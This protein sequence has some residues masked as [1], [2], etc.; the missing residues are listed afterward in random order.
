M[1]QQG[2]FPLPTKSEY[3]EVEILAASIAGAFD[4]VAIAMEQT[5]NAS[6]ASVVRMAAQNL[7]GTSRMIQERA[8]MDLA[9]RNGPVRKMLKNLARSAGEASVYLAKDFSTIVQQLSIP[10]Y[11]TTE[12]D[13]AEV[14]HDYYLNDRAAGP[15]I[16][17]IVSYP[18][19]DLRQV[20]VFNSPTVITE[21]VKIE[22]TE[23]YHKFEVNQTYRSGAHV[24][25]FFDVGVASGFIN[26]IEVYVVRDPLEGQPYRANLSFIKKDALKD[27]LYDAMLK[28]GFDEAK[29]AQLDLYTYNVFQENFTKYIDGIKAQLPKFVNASF[30]RSAWVRDLWM[31]PNL[32]VYWGMDGCEDQLF[33]KFTFPTKDGNNQGGNTITLSGIDN[34]IS[35]LHEGQYPLVFD[36]GDQQLF[37]A[38]DKHYHSD[39]KLQ[40]DPSTWRRC[41]DMYCKAY[42]EWQKNFMR[43][44]TH[45]LNLWSLMYP[46]QEPTEEQRRLFNHDD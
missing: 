19:E 11:Q 14:L 8:Q 25:I 34:K 5:M 3:S 21:N 22:V 13:I 2:K 10:D 42:E 7:A 28:I 12:Y 29:R 16:T 36:E 18:P 20:Y 9:A 4:Q 41:F 26:G 6:A 39:R 33:W 27:Q 45:D 30:R 17:L 40:F 23:H 35:Y 37:K 1:N 31:Y 46:G 32:D 43:E 15:G 24:K 38:T 44:V